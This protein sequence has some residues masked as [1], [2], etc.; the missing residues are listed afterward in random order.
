MRCI[1]IFARL[2]KSA[3]NYPP[4]WVLYPK[5][6]QWEAFERKNGKTCTK[7]A[8]AGMGRI[9]HAVVTN[10]LKTSFYQ[11][12]QFI[13]HASFWTKGIDLQWTLSSIKYHIANLCKSKIAM[14]IKKHLKLCWVQFFYKNQFKPKIL[15][16]V[17]INLVKPYNYVSLS[18]NY[19]EKDLN[20]ICLLLIEEQK[21]PKVSVLN[22]DRHLR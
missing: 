9:V 17:K 10:R 4:F 6:Q 19:V 11:F 2:F 22:R 8:F 7:K 14:R 13:N 1:S 12:D 15:N 5:G 16:L 18:D 20:A 3:L 21:T